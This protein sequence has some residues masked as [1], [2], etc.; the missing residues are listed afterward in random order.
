MEGNPDEMKSVTV[1]EDVPKEETAVKPFG[2][3]KK[4]PWDRH[5]A[6]GCREKQ[7]ER[8][9][10]NCGSRR[11]SP[12]RCRRMTRRQEWHGAG[13]TVVS[14]KTRAMLQEGPLKYGRSR[15]KVAQTRKA[16]REYGSK[17]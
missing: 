17:V 15:R 7:K 13:D 5:L 8:T 14:V 3:V 12:D 16:S 2:E 9:Q 10:G 11:K 4:R 6:I 1:H